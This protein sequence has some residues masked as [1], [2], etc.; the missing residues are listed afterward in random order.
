MK[1]RVVVTGFSTITSLGNTMETWNKICKQENG[2]SQLPSQI[3]KFGSFRTQHAAFILES[4][5]STVFIEDK[6]MDRTV[7]LAYS[8]AEEAILMSRISMNDI[9]AERFGIMMGTGA[10][11]VL[12]TG[13][14]L[15]NLYEHSNRRV[16]PNYVP[17]ATINALSG[18]IAIKLNAKGPNMT[19]S[20]ACAS[21]NHAIGL[22][23]DAISSGKAD[24]MIAGGTESPTDGLIYSGFDNMRVMAPNKEACC[25]FSANRKGFVMGEGAA[26]LVLES[27]EHAVDRGAKI[28]GEVKGYSMSCD[29]HHMLMPVED[30]SQIERTMANAL[31]HAN[32]AVEEIDYINAHG[33]GTYAGDKAEIHGIKR[34]YKESSS[35]IAPISSIKGAVGHTLGASGAIEA[36]VSLLALEKGI[37]PP[38]VN[39]DIKDAAFDVDIVTESRS[40]ELHTI[41]SNSFGFG[42]NN[43]TLVFQRYQ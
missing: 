9:V 11:S 28:Y 33:T 27:I 8:C 19:V 16:S 23:F 35:T 30:G 21:G 29:A 42:G 34:L 32:I 31:K 13:Q 37:I 10:G 22:A 18:Y 14:Q 24:I 15:A 12:L 38:N 5:D 39:L 41:V 43:C 1:N 2:Y 40:M 25:P 7:N 36:V 26:T 3:T 17:A 6:K 4:S 20:T